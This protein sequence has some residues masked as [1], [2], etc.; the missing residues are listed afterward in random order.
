MAAQI[1]GM[2]TDYKPWGGLAGIMAGNREANTEAANLLA[3]Q[4]SQLGN[5]IKG[6]E[7][8]R[9]VDDYSDPRMEALR[10]GG[11]MGKNQ[12]DIAQGATAAGTQQSDMNAKIAENL[13]KVP[14]AQV[15]KA[16]AETHQQTMGLMGLASALEQGG[17]SDLNFVAKA[18]EMAP[19]LGM[20]PQDL[21]QLLANPELLKKKLAQNQQMLTMVPAVLQKMAEQAQAGTIQEGIHAG[22]RTSHEKIASGNNSTSIQVANI[23]AQSRLDAAKMKGRATDIIAQAQ[24]GKLSYEKAA[25]AFEMMANFTDDPVEAAK[26]KDLA[27]RFDIA[28]QKSRA[29]G[30]QIPVDLGAMGVQTQ[31]VTSNLGSKEKSGRPPLSSFNK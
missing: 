29:A 3:L 20:K 23:S 21:Q 31:T 25:T 6:V 1:Q 4:E 11:I 5:A 17:G 7:A 27:S 24:A 12:V 19:S 8:G 9:A 28:N 14:K 15:E 26:Y 13:A 16:L 30:R 22:D 10:Q 18:M 2:E